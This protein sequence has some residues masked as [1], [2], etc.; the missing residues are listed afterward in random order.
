MRNAHAVRNHRC[1]TGEIRPIQKRAG[2]KNSNRRHSLDKD[3]V[4]DRRK[5]ILAFEQKRGQF[6]DYVVDQ[7]RQHDLLQELLARFSRMDY[8]AMVEALAHRGVDWPGARPAPE[9]D[10]AS[11]LRMPFDQRWR[12]HEEARAW[13]G[14][15]LRGRPVAAVDGSQITPTKDYST[16]VGAVQ[17]GWYVNYHEEGGRYVKD[18]AF[19]VLGPDE[20]DAADGGAEDVGGDFPNWLVNQKRFTG[21]CA[22]LCR[23]MHEH[24]ELPESQRPVCFLDGSLV[25]SFAGQM[26]PSR[27]QPYID[28]VTQLL[29]CSQRCRVPLVAYVDT[30]FSR[31]LVTLIQILANRG[32]APTFGDAAL[33]ARQLPAW[34]DRS[35]FFF[36]ARPDELSKDGRASFY[37]DV[38]FTYLRVVQDRAPVRVELP[39]WVLEGDLA[40]SV[41]DVVR[42]QCV[43]GSGY[44]YVVET[45]DAVAVITQQDRQRFYALWQQFMEKEGIPLTMARKAGSKLGRR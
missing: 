44:P 33:L 15:V 11:D 9:L 19:E 13:A 45:A 21:E 6:H 29:D 34:G 39:R 24:A 7:R 30:S 43:V 40:E 31:D 26:R 20:L 3:D 28:A 8:A 25:I 5:V 16:P 22:Q 14:D 23:L 10:Q 35:P 1:K 18:V 17:V 12:T 42:A 38:A 2:P 41:M 32:N 36:C 4:L 27:A 37:N